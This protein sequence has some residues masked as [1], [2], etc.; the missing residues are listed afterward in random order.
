[1]SAGKSQPFRRCCLKPISNDLPFDGSWKPWQCV[2]QIQTRFHW[3]KASLGAESHSAVNPGGG[4][5]VRGHL[6]CLRCDGQKPS[7]FPRRLFIP[8]HQREMLIARQSSES[9]AVWREG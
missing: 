2:W 6:S 9:K 3:S 7:A 4:R 8:S 1:M 5:E